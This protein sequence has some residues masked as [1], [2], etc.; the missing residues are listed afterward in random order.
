[1]P[2]LDLTGTD[3]IAIVKTELDDRNRFDIDDKVTVVLPGGGKVAGTVGAMRVVTTASGESGVG[4]GT[5]DARSIL[6]VEIA[7]E[8]APGELVGAPV[9]VVVATDKRANVLLVPVTALLALAEGGYGLEVVGDD[10]TTKIVRV[11]TGLFVNGKVE[12]RG[13][14]IAKGTVVGVA[15]R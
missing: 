3:Q 13:A 14:G 2:V 9:K 15:G 10:G 5:A 8:E 1:V 11:D 12:V 7:M 6:Q 4:G